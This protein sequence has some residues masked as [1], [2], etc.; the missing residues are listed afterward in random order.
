VGLYLQPQAKR[1]MNTKEDPKVR[2]GG[3]PANHL[4]NDRLFLHGYAPALH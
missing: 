3:G 2:R 4:A 1:L